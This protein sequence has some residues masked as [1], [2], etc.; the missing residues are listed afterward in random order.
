ME[1]AGLN[2]KHSLQNGLK[3]QVKEQ[4]STL[5]TPEAFTLT[6]S[7]TWFSFQNKGNAQIAYKD[8]KL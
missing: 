3:R 7:A 5:D 8:E 6:D 2:P 1:K 4:L